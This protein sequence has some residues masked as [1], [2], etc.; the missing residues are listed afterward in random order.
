[1]PLALRKWNVLCGGWSVI[2][3]ELV[4]MS[5]VVLQASATQK[6]DCT[7]KPT[8]WGESGQKQPGTTRA[9]H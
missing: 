5:R 4:R 9:F 6:A 7:S 1:M 8:Q 2:F 3:K